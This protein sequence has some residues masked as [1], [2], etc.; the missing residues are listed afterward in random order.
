FANANGIPVAATSEKPYS[1]D[2]NLLHIS[3]ESGLLEDP[4]VDA[5]TP[6]MRGM[7]KLSVAPEEAPDEAEYVDLIFEMGNCISVTRLG[8]GASSRERGS[9]R[10]PTQPPTAQMSPLQVM[11][12]LNQLGAKHG[13]GRVDIVENRYVGMKSR[14]VYETPGGAI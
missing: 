14:G 3:Y 4:W 7:Y 11:Q 8:G 5:S 13:I 1:T 10:S 2:R 12:T 9:T 6:A